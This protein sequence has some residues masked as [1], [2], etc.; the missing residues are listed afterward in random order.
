MDINMPV[1][2]GM[3]ATKRLRKLDKLK[4]IDLSETLIIRHSA[5]EGTIDQ[6]ELFDGI[7]KHTIFKTIF[8]LKMLYFC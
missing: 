2:N 6:I 7:C 5:I 8:F 1:M 4:Q 3:K